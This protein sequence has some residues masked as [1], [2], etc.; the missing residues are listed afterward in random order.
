VNIPRQ[1]FIGGADYK[2]VEE[3]SISRDIKTIVAIIRFRLRLVE[4]HGLGG[5]IID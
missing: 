3:Y 2:G 5:L 1:H 4:D